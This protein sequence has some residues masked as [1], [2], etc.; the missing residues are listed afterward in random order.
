M[1]EGK[2]DMSVSAE[3]PV[4]ARIFTRQN[5][6]I[7]AIIDKYQNE[8]FLTRK[9]SGIRNISDLKGRTIRFPEYDPEFFLGRLLELNGISIGDV[10][11]VNVNTSQSV[12]AITEGEVRCDHVLPAIYDPDPG[13]PRR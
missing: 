11:L 8:E 7:I 12:A 5:V 1:A 9:D 4:I 10:V 13:S 2:L 6:S 3:N